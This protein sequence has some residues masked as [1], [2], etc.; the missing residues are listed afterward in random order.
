VDLSSAATWLFISRFCLERAQ[1]EGGHDLP[2]AAV[3][4]AGI[5]PARFA[6]G[7]E[8]EWSGRLLYAGRID[9]RK[10]IRQAIEAVAQL[11]GG[12]R[13]DIVGGGDEDHRT[14][15]E[16]LA[17]TLGL[18]DRVTFSGGVPQEELSGRYAAADALLFPVV[19]PEPWGLVPLEAMA[20]GTPVIATGTGGSA[21]YLRDE[22]NCL[23]AEPGD[24]GAIASAIRRL[25]EDRALRGRLRGEG[26]KTASRFTEGAFN[27]TVRSYHERGA[28][29]RHAAA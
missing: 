27:E 5:D 28:E 26:L 15:L 18:R 2:H 3:A 25:E 4:H 9:D 7:P 12:A 16:E 22:S 29:D 1:R 23:L 20:C 19:W 13:L 6:P 10:G 8:R 14:E 17:M 21:E 11:N 24:A